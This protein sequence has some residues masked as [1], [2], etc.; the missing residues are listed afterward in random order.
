M[1]RSRKILLGLSSLT[2]ALAALTWLAWWVLSSAA[3]TPSKADAGSVGRSTVPIPQAAQV[4]PELFFNDGVARPLNAPGSLQLQ[5]R[6]VR[7]GSG[8]HAELQLR[9][10]NEAPSIANLHL[11]LYEGSLGIQALKRHRIAAEVLSAQSTDLR[12][13]LGV[14][15][16]VF[17]DPGGYLGEWVDEAGLAAWQL[18]APQALETIFVGRGDGTFNGRPASKLAPRVSIISME[19]GTE[20]MATL[21]WSPVEVYDDAADAGRIDPAPS[22]VV[23][24]G[25]RRVLRTRISGVGVDA[26]GDG[27]EQALVLRDPE[28]REWMSVLPAGRWGAVAR[29]AH[30]WAW[31]LPADVP[32]GR[33]ELLFGLRNKGAATWLPLRAADGGKVDALGRV[34]VADAEVSARADGMQLGMSF[35]RYPGR[36]V[37]MLGPIQIRYD[38]ARSLAADGMHILQWWQAVDRYEWQKVDAWADFHA[39]DGRGVIVVFTG[40]PTWASQRPHEDSVMKVPG[41]AAPPKRE[42]WS[43]YERMVA[44]TVTRLKGKLHAVECWN[45][46]DLHG[47]FSGTATELA[48]LCKAVSVQSRAVDPAVPVI[49]PQPSSPRGMPFVL[50]ARTSGGEPITK[51]CDYVGAHLYNALGDDPNG[52]AYEGIGVH[53][54]VRDMHLHAQRFGLKQRIAVTEYG[55]AACSGLPLNGYALFSKMPSAQAGE[56]LYQSIKAFRESGVSMLGLYSYDHEDRDPKCRP[57]GSFIRSTTADIFGGQRP[58]MEVLNQIDRAYVDFARR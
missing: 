11:Y 28:G 53:R 32:S 30:S 52:R 16:H 44:A 43:A 1:S 4:T 7:A 10:R 41:N 13:S 34:R 26:G 27:L 3:L 22:P 8:E 9:I 31:P 55:V 23:S 50:S 49:C 2:S 20:V 46:P 25:A 21:R 15:F 45:E 33:Y 51:F 5:T 24:V 35:H 36:S 42:L 17:G 18:D 58:D 37:H 40:S 14:G 39:R 57:G 47:S 6:V 38:F 19:P 56:A 48:D 54:Q 29:H 12:A